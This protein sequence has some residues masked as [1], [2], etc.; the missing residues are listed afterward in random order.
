MLRQ[1]CEVVWKDRRPI[2]AGEVSL[3]S[4]HVACAYGE[5]RLFEELAA[6]SDCTGATKEDAESAARRKPVV[7]ARRVEDDSRHEA[8]PAV[9]AT[10]NDMAAAQA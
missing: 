2:D 9:L 4:G 8:K 1:L 3:S 5:D 10:A 6:R 7:V